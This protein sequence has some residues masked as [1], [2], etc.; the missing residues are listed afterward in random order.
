METNKIIEFAKET[1]DNIDHIDNVVDNFTENFRDITDTAGDLV[2][3]IKVF[4]SVIGFIKK[5]K[6]KSFLKKFAENLKGEF[7]SSKQLENNRKLKEYLKYKKN[8]N[9]IYETIDSAV[10]S[11]S[12]NS[13]AAIGFLSGLILSKQIEINNKHL[14]II[15]ALKNLNDFE[16]AST[17]SIL[18]TIIDWTRP[19]NIKK[20][21]NIISIGTSTE[22]TVQKLKYLQ[23]IEEI[24]LNDFADSHVSNLTTFFTS[25][26]TEDFFNLLKDSGV[27]EELRP[28]SKA[29]P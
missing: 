4:S 16:L 7:S 17:I 19:Q 13:S 2:K 15:N 24:S 25:E 27:Y 14:L 5:Q 18:E 12:I 11:K 21:K 28:K 23:I 20:N 10:D 8:L 9:F 29:N 26:I 1:I 3:P 22:Y 6:F